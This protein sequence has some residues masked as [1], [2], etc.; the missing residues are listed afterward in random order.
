MLRLRQ[1]EIANGTSE[2][3][4][5]I[6]DAFQRWK[7]GGV[8]IRPKSDQD[9]DCEPYDPSQSSIEWRLTEGDVLGEWEVITIPHE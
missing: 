1:H 4:M 6:I 7:Q 2:G 9:F 3:H 8:M 5:N